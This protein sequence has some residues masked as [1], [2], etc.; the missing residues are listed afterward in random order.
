[1]K[2]VTQHSNALPSK[3]YDYHNRS[4]TMKNYKN[5]QKKLEYTEQ[6][7]HIFSSQLLLTVL[8]SLFGTFTS[9]I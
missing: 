5:I 4:E 2:L 8:K 1:M 6:T 3:K 9:C 7:D